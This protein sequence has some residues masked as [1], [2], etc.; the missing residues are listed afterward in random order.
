MS[1]PKPAIYGKNKKK[2][3]KTPSIILINPKYPAN[4]AKVIR[5]AAAFD[6]PQVW[7]TG[8]RVSVD[9]SKGERLPRE[10]RMKGYKKVEIRQFD[11]PLGPD[12]QFPR[13]VTPVAVEVRDNAQKLP[14]FEHPENPVYVFGPEDGSLTRVH[15]QHCHQFVIIP[16]KHCLNLA[17]AV[18]AVLY[19]RML[20][21]G[22]FHELDEDRGIIDRNDTLV[23]IL[24]DAAGVTEDD[25]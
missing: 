23:D 7:W 17:T 4:V 5:L 6:I 16:T 25:R 22:E 1:Q 18:T 19:D 10:E 13:G 14:E 20:K 9:P 8:D 12:G 24:G 15:T 3:G 11:H 21:S 2:E